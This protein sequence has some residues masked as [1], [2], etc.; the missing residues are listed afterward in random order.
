MARICLITSLCKWLQFTSLEACILLGFTVNSPFFSLQINFVFHGCPAIGEGHCMY[1]EWWNLA[2]LAA[3]TGFVLKQT[4]LGDCDLSL[5]L[6][7]DRNFTM[8]K[9]LSQFQKKKEKEKP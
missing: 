1:K 9:D 4:L 3:S 2:R 6:Q 5:S 7:S 8:K